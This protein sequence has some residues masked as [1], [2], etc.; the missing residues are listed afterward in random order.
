VIVVSHKLNIVHALDET[1]LLQD[2]AVRALGPSDEVLSIL[3]GEAR[4]ASVAA[5][6]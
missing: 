4:F 1:V 5:K 6:R 3:M 2:G